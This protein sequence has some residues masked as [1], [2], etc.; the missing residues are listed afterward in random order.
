MTGQQFTVEVIR[1]VVIVESECS[2]FKP[3]IVAGIVVV[4]LQRCITWTSIK[5]HTRFITLILISKRCNNHEDYSMGTE[6]K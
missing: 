1:V 6:H 3:L 5:K 2:N 4:E